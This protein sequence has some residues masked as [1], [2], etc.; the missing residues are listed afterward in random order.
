RCTEL[1]DHRTN[2]AD[3]HAEDT[4]R[5]DRRTFAGEDVALDRGP[6][7]AAILRGPGR[8]RPAALDQHFVP[9]QTGCNLGE[10][11]AGLATSLAQIVAEIVVQEAAHFVAEGFIFG[12]ERQIH[13]VLPVP[14]EASGA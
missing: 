9:S 8:R 10:R 5:V 1:H 6:A 3:A 12:A 14:D 11:A 2:H 13:L 4:R 7:G